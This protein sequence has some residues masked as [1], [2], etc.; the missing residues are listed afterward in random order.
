MLDF[1]ITIHLADLQFP[2]VIRFIGVELEL[3]GKI[4]TIFWHK[5][6]TINPV[7]IAKFFY[8]IYN[9]IL[10]SLFG[11]DQIERGLLKAILSYFSTIETISCG[12]L[13]LHSLV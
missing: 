11:E 1:K 6:A 4:Q 7:V 10:M 9:A 13:H 5:T 3:S 12:M 2:L 8:I